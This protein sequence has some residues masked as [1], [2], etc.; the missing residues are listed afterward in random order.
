MLAVASHLRLTLNSSIKMK[1]K[2]YITKKLGV[3]CLVLLLAMGILGVSYARWSQPLYVSST[4]SIATAPAVVTDG[5]TDLTL[6]S[7]ILNGHL[8]A[9]APGTSSVEV[10]F[11]YGPDTNYGTT[12]TASPPSVS[13]LGSTFTYALSGLSAGETIHY[14]A[15]G[16]GLWTVYG[17]DQQFTTP[18]TPTWF[19]AITTGAITPTPSAYTTIT[20]T[21]VGTMTMN[22][23]ITVGDNGH[24]YTY[25]VTCT[26]WNSYGVTK[27]V[28]TVTV[29]I[30]PTS[31]IGYGDFWG[32]LVVGKQI[33]SNS[34][35]E[36]G[37]SFTTPKNSQNGDYTATIT[38]T[39]RDDPL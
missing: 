39:L 27:Y 20:A 34:G 29:T 4:V 6:T 32:A 22:V 30:T 17:A 18:T 10:Y 31:P 9:V 25:P 36:G 21:G 5:I 2:M 37:M 12:V 11:E 8:S 33:P 35:V 3:I 38:Y 19:S 28:D 26:I 7:A 1:N 13:T 14:R 16:V 23:T 15:K 24:A